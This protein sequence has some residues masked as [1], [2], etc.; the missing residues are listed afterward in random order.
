MQ[1][2]IAAVMISVIHEFKLAQVLSSSL[3]VIEE[4]LM[5]NT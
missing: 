3:V 2:S 4:Y 1:K 5:S